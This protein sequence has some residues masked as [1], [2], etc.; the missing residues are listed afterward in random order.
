M[1]IHYHVFITAAVGHYLKVVH[2]VANVISMHI[3]RN[4]Q[5]MHSIQPTVALYPRSFENC[6]S[7]T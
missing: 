5:E 6:S 4:K 2:F 1:H 3:R 7:K